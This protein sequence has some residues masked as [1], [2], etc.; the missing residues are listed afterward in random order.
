[1]ANKLIRYLEL[2]QTRS[3]NRWIFISKHIFPFLGKIDPII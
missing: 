1:M 3:E 2:N